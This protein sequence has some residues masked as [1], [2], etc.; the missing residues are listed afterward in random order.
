MLSERGDMSARIF[1]QR[2]SQTIRL[3]RLPVQI[4]A[5]IVRDIFWSAFDKGFIIKD[6]RRDT[7][8]SGFDN[9]QYFVK[10]S[11]RQKCH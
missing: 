5:D 4:G 7:V 3:G 11:R 9:N 8:V 10:F 2:H 1:A 6:E